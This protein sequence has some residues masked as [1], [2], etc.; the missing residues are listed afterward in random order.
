MDAFDILMTSPLRPASEVACHS[1]IVDVKLSTDE[2][3]F[4]VLVIVILLSEL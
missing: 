2:A 3:K 1:R 4:I